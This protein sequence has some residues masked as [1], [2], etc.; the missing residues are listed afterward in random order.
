MPKN[1]KKIIAK[2]IKEGFTHR[3]LSSF[4]DNQIKVLSNKLLGEGIPEE[5]SN[6]EKQLADLK[7]AQSEKL[8]N[9]AEELKNPKTEE[10]VEDDEPIAPDVKAMNSSGE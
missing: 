5:I 4:S 3:T 9:D 6:A 8:A 1:R 10:V 7:L 2:L